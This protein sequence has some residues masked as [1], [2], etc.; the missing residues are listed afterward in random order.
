MKQHPHN[1]VS[2]GEEAE[3]EQKTH[4]RPTSTLAPWAQ[5]TSRQLQGTSVSSHWSCI[6]NQQYISPKQKLGLLPPEGRGHNH[7]FSDPVC[8]PHRCTSLADG[9]WASLCVPL[10]PKV[11]N[12]LSRIHN[13]LLLDA[14]L[15]TVG[16]LMRTYLL[17]QGY[18]VSSTVSKILTPSCWILN[19]LMIQRGE[20][21]NQSPNASTT[22]YKTF[23]S[24]TDRAAGPSYLVSEWCYSRRNH[25]T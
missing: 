16:E 9:F 14:Y 23:S 25:T 22:A 24:P 4:S 1:R 21:F 17:E 7:N 20:S 11:H 19:T 2:R 18:I 15:W 5:Y 12:S 3:Q 10:H 6:S 8:E 13:I